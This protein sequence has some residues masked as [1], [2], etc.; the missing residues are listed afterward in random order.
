MCTFW[1]H[2]HGCSGHAIQVLPRCCR[3]CCPASLA[4]SCDDLG[5]AKVN[6]LDD[7]VVVE[8]QVYTPSVSVASNLYE[9]RAYSRA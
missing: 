7:A 9:G 4:L 1:R 3:G 5:R 8:K 6:I 2:V